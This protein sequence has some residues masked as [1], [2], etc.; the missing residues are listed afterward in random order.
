[1]STIDEQVLQ[2]ARQAIAEADREGYVTLHHGSLWLSSRATLEQ[3][4]ADDS[5]TYAGK[6][7]SS[8]PYW[9]EICDADPMPIMGGNDENLLDVLTPE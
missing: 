9:L 3:Y 6:D 5:T 2:R 4:A 8:A 7:F 1:M